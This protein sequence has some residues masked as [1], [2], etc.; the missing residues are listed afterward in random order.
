MRARSSS[1][2]SGYLRGTAAQT[3]SRSQL[4][5]VWPGGTGCFG[6][7][8]FAWRSGNPSSV[9]SSTLRATAPGWRANS[10]CISSPLRRWAVPAAGSQPSISSRLRR[11]RSPANAVASGCRAG[12]A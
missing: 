4:M 3:S 1:L 10:R 6:R 7:F 5:G 2:A 11:A 12:V 9:A 8:G